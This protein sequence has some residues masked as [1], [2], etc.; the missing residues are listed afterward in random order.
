MRRFAW[1]VLLW[2][3]LSPAG[4]EALTG[5]AR[6]FLQDLIRIDSSN[7]PGNET[8]VARYLKG[9]ADAEGIPCRLLG[10]DTARLNFVARLAGTGAGRPLFL[11]AH[12][13][14]VPADAA[15]WTVPPFSGEI[16][17]GYIYGRGAEDDKG[18]LAAEMAVLVE[19]KRR[20]VRLRR[21]VILLAE[22]D[23]ETR[24]SGMRWLVENAWPA[25]QAE[26]A[27][28]EG[29]FIMESDSGQK[30]YHIQT[31]EK[32]PMRV[33][34]TAR[35]TSGHGSLPRPDNPVLRLARAVMRMAAADQP[36][37]LN[38]TTRRYLRAISG[39]P[40][41]RW[42]APLLPRLEKPATSLAT[43]NEIR[44]KDAEIDA[45]LRTSVAPTMLSAGSKI[46][47]IPATAEA[48]VDVRRLPDETRAE[49]LARLRQ[50]VNDPAIEI[51]PA[52]AQEM[53]ATPPSSLSTDLYRSMESTFLKDSPDAL[54]V[55]Y[56]TRGATD[57]SILRQHGMEVYGVPVFLRERGYS[58]SHGA[59][60]R[61]SVENLAAGARLLLKIVLA[62]AGP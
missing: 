60:E 54:V 20:G 52:S 40:E 23:E 38:E 13:D 35:G 19:L 36:V 11:M 17:D 14:V 5:R 29:G 7:P 39:L 22:A 58:G 4:E 8:K 16:R 43:A 55:P 15:Q 48:R 12:S 24:S 25:I 26:F 47:V 53:P 49:V 62:A 1:L 18:L 56:M 32:I 45:L 33:V 30:V 31:A 41:Y 46:N 28:N 44:R 42:L 50:A 59:D 9:V 51:V 61:I 2:P 10:D 34:L 6:S 57:G 3:V 27:L 37:R 21:D